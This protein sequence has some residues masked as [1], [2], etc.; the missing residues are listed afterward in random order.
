MVIYVLK[1]HG[2]KRQKSSWALQDAEKLLYMTTSEA[3]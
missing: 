3:L 2:H 1:G